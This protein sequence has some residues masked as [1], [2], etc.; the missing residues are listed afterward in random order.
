MRHIFLTVAFALA[1][2]SA[3]ASSIERIPAK[4]AVDAGSIVVKAC[5][6]CPPLRKKDPKRDYIVPALKPGTQTVEIRDI[7][8]EPKVVRTE[9][10][11]GGSPVV[12]VYKATP[13][14]VAAVEGEGAPAE[15]IDTLSTTAAVTPFDVKPVSASVAPMGTAATE[16]TKPLDISAFELRLQ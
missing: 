13:A 16:Q 10:W 9:A 15:G 6:D 8:G 7:N 1:A 3:A 5:A 12:F 4:P 11:M 2:G 14:A